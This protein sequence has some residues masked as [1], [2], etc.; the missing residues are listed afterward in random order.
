M[1]VPNRTQI[2]RVL[3]N[4]KSFEPKTCDG[5]ARRLKEA[6]LVLALISPAIQLAAAAAWQEGW[7]STIEQAPD[8]V[9]FDG[10]STVPN[11]YLEAL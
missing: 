9:W 8:D 6:D 5:C 11:P 10:W 7:A 1:T 3:S 4:C 2:A